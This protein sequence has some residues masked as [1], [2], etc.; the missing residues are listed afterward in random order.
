MSNT[1]L[2]CY[3]YIYKVIETSIMMKN[4]MNVQHTTVLLVI[5]DVAYCSTDKERGWG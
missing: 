2:L 1:Q 5:P 4:T 3:T